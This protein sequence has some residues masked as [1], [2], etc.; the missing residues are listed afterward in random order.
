MRRFMTMATVA[1]VMLAVVYSVEAGDRRGHSSSGGGHSGHDSHDTNKPIIVPSK[2]GN[3]GG[4]AVATTEH[5]LKNSLKISGLPIIAGKD[6]HQWKGRHYWKKY[7]CV[8]Y[9]SPDTRHW[10]YWN[11]KR[12]AYYPVES[13]ASEPP[14]PEDDDT[15]SV[16]DDD[17]DDDGPT[18][19]PD[20]TPLTR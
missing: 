1:A 7:H 18:V 16:P 17:D 20:G 4:T 10:Y 14:D 13:I 2:S 9:W 11:A 3:S 19:A 15:T 8:C 5:H 12:N 6:H